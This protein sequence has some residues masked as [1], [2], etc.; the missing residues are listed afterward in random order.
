[1]AD[2]L[3]VTVRAG[4]RRC[5]LWLDD[6]ERFVP[7]MEPGDLLRFVERGHVVVATGPDPRLASRQSARELR[8]RW[9]Q[10]ATI[11][12]S[13]R[14]P[15]G[16]DDEEAAV[17]RDL[18]PWLNVTAGIGAFLVATEVIALFEN[19]DTSVRAVVWALCDASRGSGLSEV[20]EGVVR[21]VYPSYVRA[22]GEHKEMTFDDA[23]SVATQ[24]A[25]VG[26][27]RIEAAL[28][29]LRREDDVSLL[30]V[31]TV[32]LAYLDNAPRYKIRQEMWQQLGQTE[33]RMADIVVVAGEAYRRGE[34]AVAIA[35]LRRAI[36]DGDNA[37]RSILGRVL[38]S[39]AATTEQEE[40]LELLE[41]AAERGSA[42]AARTLG[43][44]CASRQDWESAS[45]WLGLAQELGDETVLFELGVTL[46]LAGAGVRARRVYELG[47][48]RDDRGIVGACQ[49]RIAR[50]EYNAS[51]TPQAIAALD[52]A[53]ELDDDE[54][55]PAALIARALLRW[56][57]GPWIGITPDLPY[58]LSD[59]ELDNNAE[60]ADI[61]ADLR[62][63]IAMRHA[64]WGLEA[65]MA[66]AQILWI[67]QQ[68]RKA[69]L[70][71]ASRFRKRVK[72]EGAS[73]DTARYYGTLAELY[74][75]MGEKKRALKF[76]EMA[77]RE[78]S[79]SYS[80][81]AALGFGRLSLES[82][83]IDDAQSAFTDVVERSYYRDIVR[84]MPVSSESAMIVGMSSVLTF[85]PSAP[86][87][88]R[89][90]LAE[91]AE[92]REDYMLAL[93][94]SDQAMAEGNSHARRIR[95]RVL[96]E[97]DRR[98][99][100]IQVLREL[101]DQSTICRQ[102]WSDGMVRLARI[103]REDGMIRQER[104]LLRALVRDPRAL[105]EARLWA[106][107]QL[108]LANMRE[109]RLDVALPLLRRAAGS[110]EEM[111]KRPSETSNLWRC[112]WRLGRESELIESV[113]AVAAVDVLAVWRSML[114]VSHED[115]SSSG[116]A[117]MRR[118][119]GKLPPDRA[120]LLIKAGTGL[121]IRQMWVG[122]RRAWRSLAVA[123]S[124][125]AV[126]TVL[127]ALA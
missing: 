23:V 24:P 83:A 118:V 76:F 12:S 117:M 71:E 35:F 38:L 116:V 31:S 49:L 11:L 63:A 5:V 8:G 125:A 28:V 75:S 95:A 68:D 13:V 61:L 99:E 7:H 81:G 20:P 90:G 101:T 62:Q 19:A 98:R 17:A 114:A 26:S 47:L 96:L 30:R 3:R 80:V 53:I 22:L 111:A 65:H 91:V 48:T 66:L 15:S 60:I 14:V 120:N 100:A 45:R 103:R 86:S 72:R 39:E 55:A 56:R 54:S 119:L 92:H 59:L 42:D 6:I 46:E 70:E 79:G 64:F 36:S 69:A 122:L 93:S 27:S 94:H 41:Q 16:F 29:R 105:D 88:A 108:G 58:S 34:R 112:L 2:I 113:M 87:L 109:G 25:D 126:V 1:L 127:V 57:Q 82:R 33:P 123:A 97:L 106:S 18:Y 51:R 89:A 40:G 73:G 43:K 107:Y 4:G 78:Q 37:A 44:F 10:V 121:F 32:L 52:A 102:C 21:D 104:R 9:R 50:L 67:G 74:L 124:M 77:W 84:E 110:A 115:G 85:I